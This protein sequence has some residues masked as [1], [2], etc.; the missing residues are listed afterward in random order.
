M[1]IENKIN[2]DISYNQ[3]LNFLNSVDDID[4][5]ML[6]YL[7]N[8]QPQIKVISGDVETSYNYD[9]FLNVFDTVGLGGF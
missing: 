1:N 4:G 5:L 2:E 7:E 9:D 6:D 8:I 3:V